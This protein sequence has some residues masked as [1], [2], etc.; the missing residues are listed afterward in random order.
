MKQRRKRDE[1]AAE[2]RQGI[3]TMTSAEQPV[4]EIKKSIRANEAGD[5]E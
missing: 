4:E 1:K 5:S 3:K 2:P